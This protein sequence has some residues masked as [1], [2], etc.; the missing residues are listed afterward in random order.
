MSL[1]RINWRPGAAELRR[2]GIGML[3][4]GAVFAAVLYWR[5]MPRFALGLLAFAAVTGGSG[6]TG[7]R[8]GLPGYWL[9]M[10]LSLVLGTVVTPIVFALFYYGLITPMGLVMRAIGRD[11]LL[12]RR[13]NLATYWRDAA[14]PTTPRRAQ[15]QF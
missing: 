1:I 12:L 15:R 6:L 4:L 14:P 3:L 9:W 5:D 13:S 10:L 2:F 8:A 11:R 7:T